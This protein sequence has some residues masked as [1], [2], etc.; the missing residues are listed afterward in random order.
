MLESSYTKLPER[1]YERIRPESFKNPEA[2]LFNHDL[3]KELD[4]EFEDETEIANVFSG[5]KLLPGSEPIAQAY[6]GSQFGHFVPQLGDGRAHLLGESRGFDVQL[7]GSG[8]SRFSRRGDGRSALGPVIREYLVSEAMHVLG[9]PTTRAL[10][11][12][13]TGEKVLRQ[14]GSEPGG[15]LTRV[16]A[17]HLRVGTFQYFAHQR[18]EEALA[19]L[20]DYAIKRHYLQIEDASL[21]DR[22]LAFLKA[23][24]DRQGNLVAKWYGLGFIHGVMN[25]DNCSIAG[26]TIDYG[27]CAFMDEFQSQKVFSSIDQQGRYAYS[28]QMAIVKWNV[29]QLAG[30]LYPLI[31]SDR[32]KAASIVEETLH[33]T[34]TSFPARV[35]QTF[36][37]KLGFEQQSDDVDALVVDFLGYLETNVLDFTESFANLVALY[38]GDTKLYRKNEALSGFMQKWQALNP[39]IPLMEQNNPK[40]IPRNH[41]IQYAIDHAYKGDNKPFREMAIALKDPFRVVEKHQYLLNTPKPEER[42]YQTFCGT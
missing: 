27:P 21:S 15:I 23:F 6:A 7:K 32:D 22:C 9:V 25:T 13:V 16:A 30:C 20:T 3:A 2:L 37:K 26:L 38:D 19:T 29:M 17:S 14:N 24:A 35:Y 33:K 18:D 4:L 39:D 8:R 28:N 34:L 31:H 12:V 11:A 42:V 10:A 1:F 40:L 5:Q 36:S 41:Q